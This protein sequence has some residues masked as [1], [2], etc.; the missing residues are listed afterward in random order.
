MIFWKK[1]LSTWTMASE[2]SITVSESFKNHF[3]FFRQLILCVTLSRESLWNG[4]RMHEFQLVDQCSVIMPGDG[5]MHQLLSG[6]CLPFLRQKCSENGPCTFIHPMLLR[7][8]PFH[9]S[10][11]ELFLAVLIFPATVFLVTDDSALLFLVT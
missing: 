3:N 9:F 5:H 2:H 7:K 1:P 4:W 8:Y 11:L 10:R 6:C